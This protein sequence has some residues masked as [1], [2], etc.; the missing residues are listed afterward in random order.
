MDPETVQIDLK[1]ARNIEQPHGGFNFGD[2]YPI[3]TESGPVC[4]LSDFALEVS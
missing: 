1:W 3:L 2:S 4:G